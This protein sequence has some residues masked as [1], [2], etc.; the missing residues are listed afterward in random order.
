MSGHFWHPSWMLLSKRGTICTI[1]AW[2]LLSISHTTMGQERDL[3][4]DTW[5]ATDSLGRVLPDYSE[6]GSK[7]DGKYVGMFYFL[8]HGAHG[9]A[10]YDNTKLLAANP[11]D[12][13]WGPVSSFHWWGEPEAGYYLATDPWVIRR[14]ASMLAD[15]GIDMIYLDVTN[16]FTYPA[17]FRAL[18]DTYVQIRSEGGKT[19]KLLSSLKP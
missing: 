10:L 14:N 8:W 6:V 15:A 2:S 1:I 5:V 12:P 7:D 13:Q 4:S 3:Y 19:H 17:E 16:A 18:A 11:A 9:T